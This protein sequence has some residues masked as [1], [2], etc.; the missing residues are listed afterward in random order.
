M[1]WCAALAVVL[2]ALVVVTVR[3]LRRPAKHRPP[4]DAESV[5][6]AAP[7]EAD[8]PAATAAA[9]REREAAGPGHLRGRVL[10]PAGVEPSDDLEVV[11]E[12]LSRRVT[13][14]ITEQ[15][16]FDIHLPSGRYTL[17]ASEGALVGVVPDVLVRPGAPRDVDIRLAPGA[18]I[19][20]KVRLPDDVESEVRIVAVPSGRDEQSGA[21]EVEDGR[22]AIEGLI[23]GRQYDITFRGSGLRALKLTGISAPADGLQVELQEPAQVR[24]AIGFSPD[25][26]CPISSVALQVGG[27]TLVDEDEDEVSADVDDDCSFE[28]TVPDQVP[29]VTVV[30]TGD[31]WHLE[32]QVAIPPSGDPAPLCLNPPCRANPK[33]GRARLRLMLEGTGADEGFGATVTE[34]GSSSPRHHYYSCASSGDK[35]AI[36]DLKPGATYVISAS[37]PDCRAFQREVTL[38]AGDNHVRISCNRQQLIEG[39]V[40]IPQREGLGRIS[41]RCP[42]NDTRF[43]VATH[44]FE[45]RCNADA[46]TVEYQIGAEGAWRSVPIASASADDPAFVDIAPL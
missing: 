11:A 31:G 13:A 16:Q 27:K 19:R 33:E 1:R 23:A 28:L 41:V 12:D 25:G 21:P 10:Y 36:R 6:L 15:G 32:E 7:V 38:T 39:V 4:A 26:D 5:A 22:F 42:G 40:R 46:R 37:G 30:A 14:R 44:L 9:P 34:T 29:L 24:G 18:T 8:D 3:G 35:C 20:G 43:V 45:L 17:V 2:V